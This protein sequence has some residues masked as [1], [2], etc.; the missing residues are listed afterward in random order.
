MRPMQVRIDD[1]EVIPNL[2]KVTVTYA[3]PDRSPYMAPTV[4]IVIHVERND[5]EY[6]E[7]SE[8]A[9]RQAEQVLR[10]ILELD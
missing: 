2:I 4:E 3:E 8:E 7:I 1:I 6:R 5:K 10:D 9:T